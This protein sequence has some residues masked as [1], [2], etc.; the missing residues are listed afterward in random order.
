MPVSVGEQALRRSL[1]RPRAARLRVLLVLR[2]LGVMGSGRPVVPSVRLQTI[3]ER[4]VQW[5]RG[6]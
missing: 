2:A 4:A 5:E 1:V 6:P 3:G